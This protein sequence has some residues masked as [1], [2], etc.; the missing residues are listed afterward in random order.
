MR[1]LYKF[2]FDKNLVM[3]SIQQIEDWIE[4]IE[5]SDISEKV[6]KK[7]ISEVIDFWKFATTYDSQV[8]I[9][10]KGV[11]AIKKDAISQKINITCKDLI[12]SERINPFEKMFLEIEKELLQFETKY[13]G[14][15]AI[16]FHKK[17]INFSEQEI[18]LI[19][20][21]ILSAIR[22][23][24]ILYKYIQKLHKFDSPELKIYK[25]DLDV[26]ECTYEAVKTAIISTAFTKIKE[27]QWL[28]LV[29]N[30]C[31]HDCKSFLFQ[32]RLKEIAFESDYEKIFVFDFYKSEIL[33][34]KIQSQK[35]ICKETL[36][37]FS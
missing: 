8:E 12:L 33:E 7:H 35:S 27:K 34:L 15:Y 2:T 20:A 23:E 9:L 13:L 36:V 26:L 21:E 28:V 17:D 30:S 4:A 29:L 3:K 5:S 25:T 32:N 14:L 6:Q 10:E 11:I 16:R 22:G 24:V 37:G 19:K 1:S 31:D 18:I